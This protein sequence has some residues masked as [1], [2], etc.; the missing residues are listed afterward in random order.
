[1][2]PALPTPFISGSVIT[3]L[4]SSWVTDRIFGFWRY[5]REGFKQRIILC[6]SSDCPQELSTGEQLAQRFCNVGPSSTSISFPPLPPS[7][8]SVSSSSSSSPSLTTS[9]S[10]TLSSPTGQTSGG[11]NSNGASSW[12]GT[13]GMAGSTVVLIG[14]GSIFVGAVSL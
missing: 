8:S 5:H 1:M 14:L 6:L 2:R 11:S 10:S 12:R 4:P 7:L 3:L 13:W 9:P